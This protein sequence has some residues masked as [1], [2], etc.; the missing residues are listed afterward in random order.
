MTGRKTAALLALCLGL[1]GP[2]WAAEETTWDKFKAFTHQEKTQAVAAGKKVI[3]ETDKK[4]A[5]LA[6]DA[7]KATG[8]TKAAHEKNMAELKERKQAA[9]A[10]LAKLGKAS[11]EAWEASKTGF[12]NAAKE[13]GSAYDKAVAAVKK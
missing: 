8:D 1:S 10:E 9:Q 2:A 4:I 12:Q 11:G 7:K 13:L 6:K 5:A 3:A